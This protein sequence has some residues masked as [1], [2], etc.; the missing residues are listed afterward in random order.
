[1]AFEKGNIPWNKNKKSY[2]D[3]RITLKCL[4]CDNSFK[5]YGYRRAKYCSYKCF[6]GNLIGKPHG[7][8]TNP[9]GYKILKGHNAKEKHWNW[10]GGISTEDRLERVKFKR[11]IQKLIFERDN[12]TCQMCG[13]KGVALQVDHIQPW[14]EYV[15][16]RFSMDNCR[17][18]CMN[19]HYF[20]TFGKSMPN[21]VKTWGHNLLE[22]GKQP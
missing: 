8:K 22:G 12:F 9:G 15:E 13:I 3:M 6:W 14:A 1:M 4:K 10:K 20:I 2:K 21:T 5:A 16:L 17:T 19:C 7:H 18:L 11:E